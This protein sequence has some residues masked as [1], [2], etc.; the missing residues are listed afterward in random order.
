MNETY[1]KSCNLN[2]NFEDNLKNRDNSLNSISSIYP[3]RQFD[4]ISFST[5]HELEKSNPS[6]AIIEHININFI[7]NKFEPLKKMIKDN[8]D[9]LL[10]SETKLMTHFQ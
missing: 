2:R 9:I 10:V 7:R 6:R 5:L 4:V 8:I 3:D 1:D